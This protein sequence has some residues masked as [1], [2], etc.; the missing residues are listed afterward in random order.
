MRALSYKKPVIPLL[1]N[2]D[3]ELPLR[4]GSREYINFSG[5]FD[6]AVARLRQHLA[7]MDSPEGQLQ[8]LKH[9]LADAER[10]LP[11]AEPDQQVRI[12]EDI[13]ELKRQIAQQ[14]KVVDNPEA[15]KQQVNKR[16][17]AGLEGERKPA[18]PVGGIATGKFINPP[19]LIAP[20]NLAI[21]FSDL[22]PNSRAIE[23]LEQALAIDREVGDRK[24]EA[25]NLGLLGAIYTDIGQNIR[26]VE[27][28]EQALSID[29]EIESKEYESQDL[30]N[31]GT[32]YQ[33]MGRP[34]EALRCY[35]EALDV[36]RGIGYRLIEAESHA[37]IGDLRISQENWGE[38]TREL[39]QA[40]EIADDIGN[41][42]SSKGAR[43]SLAL[44][45]VYRN[46]L[47]QAREIAEAA[48]EYDV[49]LS[50]HS[51]CAVLGVV[52]LRQGDL[53]SAR[54]AF[55]AAIKEASELIALTANLYAAIDFKGLSHCGLAL[56]GDPAQIPAAK[57][58]YKAARAVT[59][60]VGIV[61]AVLQRFDALAQADTGGILAEVRP[62]A[63][64]VKPD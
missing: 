55:T 43:E 46:N 61:R 23:C 8:A 29:H 10:E 57:A 28:Y 38:A 30:V 56:C 20:T 27:Y 42:D 52:A 5:P 64:G 4:L 1:L 44:V 7:W 63:A 54:E 45:N 21:S 40:I 15:A 32:A 33:D 41:P 39:E 3:A 49:R 14:Q 22:G 47:G 18:Q 48:R 9:R 6:P 19:P 31:L 17:D 50:N 51:T 60:D 12:K 36:A 35:T 25:K 26:A 62:V 2:P 13:D 34:D 53:N 11:R 59:S 58:A 37:Q 24:G 16:V